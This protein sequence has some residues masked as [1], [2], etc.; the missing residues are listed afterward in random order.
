MMFWIKFISLPYAIC[1]DFI[2]HLFNFI[3]LLRSLVLPLKAIFINLLSLCAC[4]G[5][6]VLVF[7]D[8]YLAKFLNFEA[9]GIL[10]ISL[11]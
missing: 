8:G 4:Y 9:Q 6:L 2:F 7:Q 11:L 1:V 10:D 5:A 3:S